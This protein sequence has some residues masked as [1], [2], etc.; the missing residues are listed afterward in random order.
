MLLQVDS[1]EFAEPKDI[2]PELKKDFWD[3][4]AS[5]KWSERKVRLVC[6]RHSIRIS[7]IN[8]LHSTSSRSRRFLASAS[9]A[10]VRGNDADHVAHTACGWCSCCFRL[11]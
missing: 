7:T 10:R 5:A 8:W 4:L 2:I 9:T 3:G 6:L 11:R 1:Y